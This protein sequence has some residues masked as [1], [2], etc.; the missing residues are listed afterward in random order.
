MLAAPIPPDERER[1][2]A[3]RKYEILDSEGEQAFDDLTLLATQICGAPT[4]LISL[5]DSDRQWFKARIGLETCETPREISFCG[6]AILGDRLFV[7]EDAS[8]DP[9]FS[10]NPLVTDEPH[11]RF[12]AGAPLTTPSGHRIGTL[13]VIDFV[14]RQLTAEQHQGMLALA[15]QVVALLELRRKSGLLERRD[16][17]R[18]RLFSV[19]SHD[20]R[21]AFTGLIGHISILIGDHEQ[22]N[23]DLIQRHA[24]SA[25]RQARE[26]LR[27]A[28]DLLAWARAE[29]G[30]LHFRPT[31][32]EVAEIIDR[33]IELLKPLADDKSVDLQVECSSDL[34]IP[35]DDTLLTSMIRNL[36][37]NAIKFSPVGTS[38]EIRAVNRDGW[39]VI[40]IQDHGNGI[41]SEQVAALERGDAADTTV[42]TAGERGTGLGLLTTR[43]FAARHGGSLNMVS[44]GGTLAQLRLPGDERRQP[45]DSD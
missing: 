12:Y 21:T 11:I 14:P 42:G 30:S 33:C 2:G 36:L 6:H 43:Q 38:V 45:D 31:T 40:E 37:S 4:A 10:D 23:T 1:L 5:V 32:L 25:R 34:Q 7:I 3:L 22:L 18:S 16:E 28:E 17:R 24:T 26:A 15:R 19:V 35:A 44:A 27:V 9:R 8:R 39:I 41:S 20:L 29:L 13:C